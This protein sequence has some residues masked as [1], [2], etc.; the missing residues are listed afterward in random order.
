M[1]SFILIIIMAQVSAEI[2]KSE[3]YFI[4]EDNGNTVAAIQFQGSGEITLPIPKDVENL[5]VEG[6]LYIL[7]DDS[8]TIS[9]AADSSILLYKTSLFTEK[10]GEDWT[11]IPFLDNQTEK[12]VS[13][14]MPEKMIIKTTNPN[15]QIESGEF[16]KLHFENPNEIQ[17]IYHFP[18]TEIQTNVKEN[19]F[20]IIFL[21][22]SAGIL[23]IV[24][25]S[26]QKQKKIS[27]RKEQILQ[28]L[29]ENETKVIKALLASSKPLKRKMLARKL[30]LAKSSLAATLNNLERK[31]IIEID[32]TYPSHLIKLQEW[33]KKL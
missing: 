7:E 18:S 33:F 19:N 10:T 6:A 20:L 3:Y 4:I 12:S 27:G 5:E 24:I 21:S 23:I 9:T 22:I 31:K 13:I 11:F 26:I 29:T 14:A 25:F 17:I 2:D 16:L 15:A 1:F 32:K 8:I 30:D 28:T